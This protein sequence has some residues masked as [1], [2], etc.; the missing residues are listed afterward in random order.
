MQTS[1][2]QQELGGQIKIHQ[3]IRKETKPE[4]IWFSFMDRQDQNK[5][6]P[7]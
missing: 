6:L 7:K 4:E 2:Q 1:N 5:P 3:K